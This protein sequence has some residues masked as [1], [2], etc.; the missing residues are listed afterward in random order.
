L[1]VILD[2]NGLTVERLVI[3]AAAR[4][5]SGSRGGLTRLVW[6]TREIVVIG[7]NPCERLLAELLCQR[8]VVVGAQDVDLGGDRLW[9]HG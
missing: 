5:L 7:L 1:L 2:D 4:R 8:L 3:L 6:G 9:Q